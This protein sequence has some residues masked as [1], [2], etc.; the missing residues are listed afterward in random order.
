MY[1]NWAQVREGWTKNL[2]LLFP[3]PAKR[4]FKLTAWWLL[5]WLTLPIPVLA[6]KLFTRIERANF[7]WGNTLLATA[8]GAPVFSY[9]LLRSRLA[10][11]RGTVSWKG[12]AYST[13][14]LDRFADCRKLGTNN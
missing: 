8:F 11:V 10:H 1:R 4:A 9:L 6:F 3:H 12:R 2:A 7:D 5:A 13:P 14:A